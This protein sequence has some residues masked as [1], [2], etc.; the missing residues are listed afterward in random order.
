VHDGAQLAE[1]EIP[2]TDPQQTS[3]PHVA[4]LVQLDPVGLPA[5]A[6][7]ASF[8][9][10]SLGELPAES[11]PASSAGGAPASSLDGVETL[12]HGPHV[13][14]LAVFVAHAVDVTTPV[15]VAGMRAHTAVGN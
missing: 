14:T 15:A 12:D 5:S 3:D 2:E 8:P 13:G 4:A 6:T 7:P 9:A 1:T 10:S 11:P